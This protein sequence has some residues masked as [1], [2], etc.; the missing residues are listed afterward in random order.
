MRSVQLR[1]GTYVDSVTLMQVSRRVAAV[2]GVTSALVAMATELNLDLAAGMGFEGRPRPPTS[3]WSPSR[4]PPCDAALAEVDW[5]WSRRPGRPR[6]ASAAPRRRRPSAR[7]RPAR[8][9]PSRS[10]RPPAGTPSSRR[11]TRWTRGCSAM[12]FSDNVPVA[13]EVALKE[14]AGR[15][16]PAGDGSRLRHRRRRR[17]RAGLRQRRAARAG[18]ASWRRPAPAPSRCGAARRRPASGSRTAWAS[19]AGTCPR[20]WAARSTLP[21][22]DLLDADPATELI[23]VVS[24]PPAPEV[25]EAVRARRADAGA[26]RWCRPARAGPARPDRDRRRGR[27]GHRWPLDRSR[28]WPGARPRAGRAAAVRCAGCSPAAPLRRGDAASPSAV[29]GPIYSNIPLGPGVGARRRPARATATRW[30]TSATT[31]SPSAGRTR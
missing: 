24:K 16:R 22:L 27:A 2:D 15:A 1:R 9:R 11:W 5:P 30:S 12:V 29:L 10:S 3:W 17:R 20:R 25:A 26:P 7:P 4:P 13:Q 28:A 8:R 19:A 6:P 31:S 14:D 21:A 18:R 23:V